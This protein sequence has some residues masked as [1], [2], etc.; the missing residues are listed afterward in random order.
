VIGVGDNTLIG[1]LGIDSSSTPGE[2]KSASVKNTI[3]DPPA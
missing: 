2:A 1:K 3:S